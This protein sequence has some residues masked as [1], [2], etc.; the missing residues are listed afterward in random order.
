MEWLAELG[1]SPGEMISLASLIFTALAIRANTHQTRIA[2]LFTLMREHREIWNLPLE[3]PDLRRCLA[4]ALV[5]GDDAIP[6]FEERMFVRELI[7]LLAASYRA[8][9]YG[10]YF[11]EQG[12]EQDVRQFFSKP[13]PRAVWKSL[14]PYQ[15]V[16]FRQ[17]ID[18]QLR[19]GE[20]PE[21]N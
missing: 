14:R 18:S 12:L 4:D 1:I 13:I 3:H 11:H 21:P 5:E 6:T 8:R 19:Q 17:F 9:S 2:N 7:N 10:M 20:Q 16:A 15:E